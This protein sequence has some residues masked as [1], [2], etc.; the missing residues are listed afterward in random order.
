MIKVRFTDM[1]TG[2]VTFP[3]VRNKRDAEYVY[4]HAKR[5]A[6]YTVVLASYRLI[7]R[8]KYFVAPI[9][10]ERLLAWLASNRS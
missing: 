10:P 2:K 4:A 5:V 8:Q 9:P 6:W 7:P 3:T 1:A